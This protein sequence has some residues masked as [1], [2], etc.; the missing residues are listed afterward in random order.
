MSKYL[1]GEEIKKNHIYIDKDGFE[2]LFLGIAEQDL[3]GL[4]HRPAAHIYIKMEIIN[5]YPKNMLLDEILNDLN[6]NRPGHICCTFKVHR[7]LVSDI[8]IDPRPELHG[9]CANIFEFD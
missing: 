2:L 8:G 9:C 5:Q 1:K 6:L 3:Y 4:L 7:K